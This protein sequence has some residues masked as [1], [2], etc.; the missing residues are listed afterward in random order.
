MVETASSMRLPLGAEAPKF[1]L[2]DARGMRVA[3][4]DFKGAKAYLIVFMCNHCPFV[5]HILDKLV[6]VGNE[7]AGKGVAVLAINSNDVENFPDDSPLQMRRVARE[8]GFEFPY[9]FDETQVVAKAYAAACTPD[10][11]IFD[12]GRKLVYRGQFDDSRPGNGIPVTGEDLRRALDAV[13]AG[14]GVP[15]EQRPS[16]GCGIK[17]M[18]GNEPR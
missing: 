14:K 15:A 3:L 6:D 2:K 5:R 8:K 18:A 12:A 17:W 9:L 1:T 7:Y 11:F 10:F 16:L 4:D 13:L